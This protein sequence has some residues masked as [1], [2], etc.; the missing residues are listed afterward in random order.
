[1]LHLS[2]LGG[3]SHLLCLFLFCLQV[4]VYSGF[5][6]VLKDNVP[7]KFMMLPL[8]IRAARQRVADMQRLHDVLQRRN[9]TMIRH[10]AELRVEIS[11]RWTNGSLADVM[12]TAAV[13]AVQT[14]DGLEYMAVPLTQIT[15]SISTWAAR[16]DELTHGRDNTRMSARSLDLAAHALNECGVST[17]RID[18]RLERPSSVTGRYGYD[19]PAPATVD[20]MYQ[21]LF[22]VGDY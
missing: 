3:A 5:V 20:G 21:P 2:N 1:M 4:K 18:R 15:S 7:R 19:E 11:I 12:S 9:V 17:D 8:T 6:H 10:A 16:C 14:L 13:Y 22:E